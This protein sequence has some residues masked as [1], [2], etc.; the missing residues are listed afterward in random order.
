MKNRIISRLPDPQPPPEQFAPGSQVYLR[1]FRLGHPGRVQGVRRG[2]VMVQWDDWNRLCRHRAES[3]I[4]A[5]YPPS[6]DEE[7][8]E[9]ELC[10]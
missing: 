2:I 10:D 4:L 8:E 9:E 5:E 7:E 3:L 1:N 6:E